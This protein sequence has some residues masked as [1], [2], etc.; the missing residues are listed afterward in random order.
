MW[1]PR[2]YATNSY[3]WA[4]GPIMRAK[5]VVLVAFA[6]GHRTIRRIMSHNGESSS[7]SLPG[8]LRLSL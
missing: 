5:K 6:D 4:S 1:T 8:I 7:P 3:L 2:M